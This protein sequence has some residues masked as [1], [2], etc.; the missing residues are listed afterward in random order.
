MIAAAQAVL[1]RHR[2]VGPVEVFHRMDWLPG[3]FVDDWERGRVAYLEQKAAV[4]PARLAEARAI[5][6]RWARA[7]GL[8]P[9][10][11]PYVSATRD[12]H[13][14]RFTA[15][16]DPAVER[17]YRTKWTSPALSDAA[18]DRLIQRQSA[19]PDLVVFSAVRDWTCAECGDTG[20]LLVSE[21]EQTLC[22][23]C[24]DLD[25][26]VFLPAGDAALTRRAKKASTLSAVV[27]RFNRSRKR[28]DRLGLLVEP[29]ALEAAERQCLGDEEARLRRRERDRELRAH[30]DVELMAQMAEEILRL[31][32]GCP[33]PRAEAIAAHT[34]LRGSGRV[35]RSAA[36]RAV[37][38]DAMTRAVIAS[39][40][41]EDTEYDGLL[42]SGVA[43]AEARERIRADIDRVLDAW[44]RGA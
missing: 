42:M 25:H 23:A 20:E 24:T 41:H 40:R 30:Q 2:S 21:H 9:A 6:E 18:R 1:A 5:F 10:E 34:G 38:Q 39:I 28:Y 17:A 29:A 3:T 15:D 33:R 37:Q 16:G 32:P 7:E 35:G 22:L 43:R 14:L 4:P 44:R 11:V 27:Q 26:L 36:G 19:P 8:R 31:F 12:R 13:P